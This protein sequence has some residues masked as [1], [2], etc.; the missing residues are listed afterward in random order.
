MWYKIKK[1]Q[2]KY[3]N[4]N[5]EDKT[6]KQTTQKLEEGNEAPDPLKR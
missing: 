4:T 5:N 1:L 2:K 6:E 3:V